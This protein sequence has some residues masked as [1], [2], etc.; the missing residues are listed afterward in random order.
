MLGLNFQDLF[1]SIIAIIL[2]PIVSMIPGYLL[3]WAFDIFKFRKRSRLAKYLISIVLSNATM[4]V[5]SYLVSRFLSFNFWTIFLIATTGIALVIHV[6]LLMIFKKRPSLSNLVRIFNRRKFAL[7]V[8]GL[9]VVFSLFLLVDI[10][11]GTKL[12]SANVSYDYTTRISIIN[13][14]SRTGI[15]PINPSYFPGHPEK[16]TYLY[17]YWY[18]LPSIINLIGGNLINSRQ[19]MIAG[20]IWSGICLMSVI[21]LYLRRR[22]QNIKKSWIAPLIGIQLLAVSGL[23]FIPVVTI[24]LRARQALG[25]MMFQGGVEGWNMPVM[26]WLNAIT[27]VPNHVSAFAQCATAMLAILTIDKRD[28]KQLIT[29]GILSGICFASAFGTSTWVTL[30]FAWRGLSGRLSIYL[31]KSNV[32]YFGPWPELAY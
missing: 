8:G 28:N 13:A 23:D 6:A 29:A 18:I 26:S 17:Y 16:L 31:Q 10:Q 4:P 5:F 14:I 21:G 19:A 30:V 1:G 15:P 9:W 24:D 7:L 2:F 27:W 25:H 12:Y 11:I 32:N 3:G 20:T 22:N